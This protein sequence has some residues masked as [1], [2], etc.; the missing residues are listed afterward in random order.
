[1][2]GVKMHKKYRSRGVFLD[3][4]PPWGEPGTPAT[5]LCRDSTRAPLSSR[6]VGATGSYRRVGWVG[7]GHWSGHWPT[8]VRDWDGPWLGAGMAGGWWTGL[9]L[10]HPDPLPVP[11][12]GDPP[13]APRLPAGRDRAG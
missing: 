13:A 1:M 8:G 10:P 2:P 5:R 6:F 12:T 7:S 3:W 9:T 4:P 11:A